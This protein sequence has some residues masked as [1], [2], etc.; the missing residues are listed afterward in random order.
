MDVTC[1]LS[2]YNLNLLDKI[3]NLGVADIAF[4]DFSSLPCYILIYIVTPNSL[5][6]SFTLTVV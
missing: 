6:N 2:K 3:K 5:A 1:C 4:K